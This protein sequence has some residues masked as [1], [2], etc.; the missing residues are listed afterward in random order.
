MF[1]VW[2]MSWTLHGGWGVGSCM[3]AGCGLFRV[4]ISWPSISA[5]ITPWILWCPP[6]FHR[7]HFL[8]VPHPSSLT[9]CRFQ[10][11]VLVLWSSLVS[12]HTCC[13]SLPLPLSYLL[14]YPVLSLP[15]A[16]YDCFIPPSEWDSTM[17]I[18][19]FLFLLIFQDR[20]SL[21]SRGFLKLN[22]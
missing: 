8:K 1:L 3:A 2:L 22:L 16:S 4:H 6:M 11:I 17:L 5:K 18:W 14:S 15:S 9:C 19:V 12:H 20:F 13:C 7:V 10:F 21:C